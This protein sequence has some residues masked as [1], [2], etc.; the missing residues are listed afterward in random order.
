MAYVRRE[1]NHLYER[2][3][4]KT[5]SA[6][7]NGS[8]LIRDWCLAFVLVVIAIAELRERSS[9]RGKNLRLRTGSPQIRLEYE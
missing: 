1:L 3:L 5:R 8:R 9:E 7:I 2:G 6:R 4:Y